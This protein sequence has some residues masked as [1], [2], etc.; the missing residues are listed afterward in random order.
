MV[1]GFKALV[2]RPST[3]GEEFSLPMQLH[4]VTASL[5][6]LHEANQNA[7]IA[8]R[9]DGDLPTEFRLGD[10]S[11]PGTGEYTNRPLAKDIKYRVFVRAFTSSSVSRLVLY[12]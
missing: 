11:K 1:A 8:A 7:W 2:Q 12:L 3:D 5:S 4:N 6:Q 9:Y 10:G